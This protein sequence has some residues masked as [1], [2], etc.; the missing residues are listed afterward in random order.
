MGGAFSPE[1]VDAGIIPRLCSELF[2]VRQE[3]ETGGISKWVVEVGFV[4]VYNEKVSDLLARRKHDAR[5]RVAEADND[6]FVEPR[7]CPKRGIYLEGQV[8]KR[9]DSPSEI[10]ALLELGN[11]VRHVAAT[12]MN[13]RSSRSHAGARQPYPRTWYRL[14]PLYQMPALHPV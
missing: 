4:E 2:Q 3:I 5:G 11:Q 7:G 6:V 13:H 12:N 8:L 14:F 1:H 10:E 9:V